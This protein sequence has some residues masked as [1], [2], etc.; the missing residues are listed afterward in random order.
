M[1][2]NNEI[3]KWLEEFPEPEPQQPGLFD[4]INS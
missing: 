4:D 2:G 3:F 1:L